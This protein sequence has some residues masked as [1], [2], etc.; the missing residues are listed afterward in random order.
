[1]R[2]PT[3]A[4]AV[5]RGINYFDVAPSYGNAEDMLGPALEPHRKGV[6]LAC[7]TQG[8]TKEAATAELESELNIY[9]WAAYLNPAS[10]KAFAKENGVKPA[11]FSANSEGACPSC[12]G[13]GQTRNRKKVLI[14]VPEGTDTGSKIRLKG[15][16][17][18]GAHG[19]DP[20][21]RRPPQLARAA[22]TH[23]GPH[24]GGHRRVNLGKRR[25]VDQFDDEQR[26]QHPQQRPPAGLFTNDEQRNEERRGQPPAGI[27]EQ[28]SADDARQRDDRLQRTALLRYSCA[29]VTSDRERGRCGRPASRSAPGTP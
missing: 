12:N 14:T 1:M 15:Q 7:K 27:H 28:R 6:F 24:V 4:E 26:R 13:A 16:G 17:G 29:V 2:Y 18:K 25:P 10:R 9:N 5:D 21:D 8:R 20:G 22:R 23:H 11:L 3:V 19:G